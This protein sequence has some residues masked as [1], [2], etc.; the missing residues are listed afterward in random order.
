MLLSCGF[1]AAGGQRKGRVIRPGWGS[2]VLLRS[3]GLL[4]LLPDN[5][6][7]PRMLF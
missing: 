1:Y 7:G 3:A 5:R 6:A 4:V 2:C